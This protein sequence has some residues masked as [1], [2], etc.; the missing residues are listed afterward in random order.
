MGDSYSLT[1]IIALAVK[2]GMI[3]P[4]FRVKDVMDYGK[5]IGLTYKESYYRVVLANGSAETHSPTYKK[6]FKRLGAGL[7][8]LSDKGKAEG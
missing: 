5:K 7:Y 1:T 3:P 4:Q 8:E 6:Y 2:E